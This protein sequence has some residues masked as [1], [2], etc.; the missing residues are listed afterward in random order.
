MAT[1][2]GSSVLTTPA[3]RHII[4]AAA[5]LTATSRPVRALPLAGTLACA[6]CLAALTAYAATHIPARLAVLGGLLAA[7]VGGEAIIRLRGGPVAH[8]AAPPTPGAE[9]RPAPGHSGPRT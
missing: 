2:M 9:G 6:A 7:A 5:K 8:P 1:T 4:F 3:A